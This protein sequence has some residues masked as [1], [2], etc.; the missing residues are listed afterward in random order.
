M[1]YDCKERHLNQWDRIETIEINLK[2]SGQ[3]IFEE[4]AIIIIIQQWE[5]DTLPNKCAETLNIHM[6]LHPSS[7]R[8]LTFTSEHTQNFEIVKSSNRRAKL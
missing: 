6:P 3:L 1:L 8:T 4:G 5:E 7:K 2:I